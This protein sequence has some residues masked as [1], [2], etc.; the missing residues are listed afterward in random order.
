MRSADC[1]PCSEILLRWIRKRHLVWSNEEKC[2]VVKPEAF[3]RREHIIEEGLSVNRRSLVG[4]GSYFDGAPGNV[5]TVRSLH[6]GRVRNLGL[7]VRPTGSGA[8]AT[9][10][11]LPDP[12]ESLEAHDAALDVAE[13]LLAMS[14]HVCYRAGCGPDEIRKRT[15]RELRT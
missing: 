12:R 1:I 2:V 9:I 4:N 6:T 5:C 8:H 3:M 14:R 10:F 15:T 13:V 11:G 7:C